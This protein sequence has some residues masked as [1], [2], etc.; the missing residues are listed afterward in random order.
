MHCG[1][2][3]LNSQNIYGLNKSKI[4]PDPSP[5][6]LQFEWTYF[7]PKD[8]PP[9]PKGS[10]SQSILSQP[11]ALANIEVVKA[12]RDKNKKRLLFILPDKCGSLKYS[13]A[14]QTLLLCVAI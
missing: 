12:T 6:V 14:F 13:R 1:V 9:N 7:K 3:K 4:D 10:V 8:G 5:H 2:R 11:I